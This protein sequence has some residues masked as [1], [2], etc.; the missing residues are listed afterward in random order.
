MRKGYVHAFFLRMPDG[1]RK[2]RQVS[3]LDGAVAALLTPLYRLQRDIANRKEAFD[4]PEETA[5]CRTGQV[6]VSVLRLNRSFSAGLSQGGNRSGV[7]RRCG[8]T[9]R[10]SWPC[11]ACPESL[12]L[13]L[14]TCVFR[15]WQL[16]GISER[17]PVWIVCTFSVCYTG[18]SSIRISA[19]QGPKRAWDRQGS[20]GAALVFHDHSNE[21][22]GILSLRPM[23]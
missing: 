14:Y 6:S 1:F 22:I 21:F 15:K 4:V 12:P 13:L 19:L 8:R 18:D 23:L 11:K 7:N 17:G 5:V 10:R 16:Q 9:G 2:L 3:V 20:R